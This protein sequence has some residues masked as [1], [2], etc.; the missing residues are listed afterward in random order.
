MPLKILEGN[1][2]TQFRIAVA[3][4]DGTDGVRDE[5]YYYVDTFDFEID[6]WDTFVRPLT[7]YQELW[8]NNDTGLQGAFNP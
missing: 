8:S 1:D 6:E 3:D 2:A 4:S 5:F 7:D